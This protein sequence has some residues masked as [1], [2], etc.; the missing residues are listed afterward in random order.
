MES[1]RIFMG[2]FFLVFGAFK[3]ASLKEFATTYAEYDLIAKKFP[4]YGYIY[5]FIE[6]ALGL[7]YIYSIQLLA[8][9]LITSLLM[10][11]G[12]LGI[13]QTM[14]QNKKIMCACLGTVVKLPLTHISLLEDVLMGAMALSAL[15][16]LL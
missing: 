4:N 15:V 16:Y 14:K 13:L 7:S 5:P 10:I 3:I 2:L 9:N 6:L 11:I 1:M 12:S 8:T